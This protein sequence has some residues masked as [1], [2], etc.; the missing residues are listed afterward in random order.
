MKHTIATKLLAILMATMLL[1]S[2][3]IPALAATTE[4]I[5]AIY[6]NWQV[7]A[8]Q[9]PETADAA[10]EAATADMLKQIAELVGVNPEA[11]AAV[12]FTGEDWSVPALT[13][14]KL[15]ATT[16][17]PSTAPETELDAWAVIA[18]HY[19]PAVKRGD[20]SEDVKTAQ[21]AL[22]AAGHNCGTADGIYGSKT[23]T[24]VKAFQEAAGLPATGECDWATSAL[25]AAEANVEP[26]YTLMGA[27]AMVLDDG[28]AIEDTTTTQWIADTDAL[29]ATNPAQARLNMAY[30]IAV[31]LMP[32]EPAETPEAPTPAPTEEAPEKPVETPEPTPTPAPTQHVHKWVDVTET[33][34]VPEEG[35]WDT[36]HYEA[37]THTETVEHPEEGHY[38]T[39]KH[40]AV[41]HTE[42]VEH[43][44]TGHWVDV[45]AVTHVVHHDA[46]THEE[47]K[48]VVDKAAWTETKYKSV[49]VCND[50]GKQFDTYDAWKAHQKA[51][52]RAA[53]AA[54]EAG[55]TY[56][57]PQCGAYGSR[58]VADGT[59]EHPEEGHYEN[60]TITDSEAWDETV[61]DKPASREYVID[62][63]AWTETI[64]VTDKAAWEE[65]VWKVDKAA[66]TE[67]K[68]VTD[69]K[70]H[71]ER[72]WIVDKKATTKTVVTGQRCETCGET[73][74]K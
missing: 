52:M 57:G 41:T 39:V 67:T 8:E 19:G 6:S 60:V 73:R 44:A 50:C 45:P 43:E 31:L 70:A 32:S 33:V 21:T 12:D 40:P 34:Q 64:T 62:K 11:L 18:S 9:S 71:D 35:H 48:W 51:Q 24:A 3:C 22:N 29:Y 54:Q 13:L 66:W 46:V 1:A 27:T 53:I 16:L 49:V 72:V 4:T 59:I 15:T 65:K 5:A 47:Q 7:A 25:L 56:T 23:E 20:R 36:V 10:A 42:T 63:A 2:I 17:E 58:Q 55:E 28:R 68:T 74:A 26:V 14:A 69:T 38:E 30:A 37:G 61:T